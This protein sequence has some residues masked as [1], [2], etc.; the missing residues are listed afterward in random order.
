M[1]LLDTIIDTAGTPG[2]FAADA[3][4]NIACFLQLNQASDVTAVLWQ[5]CFCGFFFGVQ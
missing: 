4:G 5:F 2:N 1:F 3:N